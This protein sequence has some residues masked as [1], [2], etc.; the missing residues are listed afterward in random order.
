MARA[1]EDKGRVWS[2]LEI[3]YDVEKP[4]YLEV[5]VRDI[6]QFRIEGD[7]STAHETE[8]VMERL[9]SKLEN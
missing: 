5:M 4:D 6:N 7:E 1:V 9:L 2:E 8:L 3:W